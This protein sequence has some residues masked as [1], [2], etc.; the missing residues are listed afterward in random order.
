MVIILVENHPVGKWKFSN[1]CERCSTRI[2]QNDFAATEGQKLLF[3]EQYS[4]LEFLVDGKRI[5]AHKLIVL[6]R[7][8]YFT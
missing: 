4:D 8:E 3:S 6:N 5:P 2:I 7:C 1:S